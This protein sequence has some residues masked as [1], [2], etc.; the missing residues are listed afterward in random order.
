MSLLNKDVS[1]MD[2]EALFPPEFP[3]QSHC[4]T[5]RDQVSN[6]SL[7]SEGAHHAI[8]TKEIVVIARRYHQMA[9][10]LKTKPIPPFSK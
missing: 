9:V 2:A 6:E 3:N 8:V 7:S 10:F 5:Y 1:S 4:L